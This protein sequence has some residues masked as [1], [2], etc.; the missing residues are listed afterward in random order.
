MKKY[1]PASTVNL[2]KARLLSLSLWG[3]EAA[4]TF[5]PEEFEAIAGGQGKPTGS[6]VYEVDHGFHLVL[7]DL[8]ETAFLA[9]ITS[10]GFALRIRGQTKAIPYI[11][12]WAHNPAPYYPDFILYTYE[13]QIAFVEIKSILGMCQDENIAKFSYLYSY[14]QK[15]G[16]LCG[17][18]DSEGYS[19][20]DY[21]S[22][23]EQE[24]PAIVASFYRSYETLGGF[25]NAA[26]EALCAEFKKRKPHEIKRLVSALVLLDP[27]CS[28]RYCHDSP[29]LLNA[30]KVPEPLPF[31]RF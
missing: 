8:A 14:C 26:L 1:L 31:K 19:V 4:K 24:D 11:K 30:V 21:L 13:H 28:D 22:L 2:Q 9:Q 5:T 29:Y 17:F 7:N 12:P 18:F 16:F 15:N 3:R 23:P 20:S 10:T 6:L 27:E 25:N